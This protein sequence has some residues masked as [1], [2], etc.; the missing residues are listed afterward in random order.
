MTWD[1]PS[2]GDPYRDA[3]T[4]EVPVDLLARSDTGFALLLTLLIAALA[5]LVSFGLFRFMNSLVKIPEPDGFFARTADIK[6]TNA[7]SGAPRFEWV[8]QA[9]LDEAEVV[10]SQRPGRELI[11]DGVTLKRRV[12]PFFKPWKNTT[13]QA[14]GFNSIH[15]SPAVGPREA[16]GSFSELVL[17]ATNDSPNEADNLDA[18]VIVLHPKPHPPEAPKLKIDIDRMLAQLVAQASSNSNPSPKPGPA[19]TG[20]P[21]SGGSRGQTTNGTTSEHQEQPPISGG[22][23]PS[24]PPRPSTGS[25]SGSA[26]LPNR[27]DDGPGSSNPPPP[28]P[29]S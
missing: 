19:P 29:K 23:V 14:A 10:R 15:T 1:R 22:N 3:V 27:P 5:V 26:P 12:P 2:P 6:I 9:Q 18:R 25:E 7:N 13:T 17:L 20:T 11:A 16:P 4:V 21:S 24:P 8:D 28:R